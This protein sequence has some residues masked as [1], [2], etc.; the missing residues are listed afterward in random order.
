MLF[1]YIPPYVTETIVSLLGIHIKKR[2]GAPSSEDPNTV[3]VI[4]Q[5]VLQQP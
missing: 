3:L 2:A 1:M 5:Y 4:L